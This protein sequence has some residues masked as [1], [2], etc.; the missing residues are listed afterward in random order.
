LGA[1]L[2]LIAAAVLRLSPGD[3][4]HLP[5]WPLSRDGDLVA[6][7]GAPLRAEGAEVERLG[8][9]LWSVR[10]APGAAT[11]R[12][13]AGSASATAPVEPAPGTIA[14][15]ASPPVAVKGRDTE[16]ALAVTVVD[17][18]GRVDPGTAAPLL[19]CSAGSI[20]DL[21]AVGP[22]R[23]A[24]RYQLPAAHYPEL[25]VITALAPRCPLCPTPRAVGAT[26]VPLSAA[27]D[28]PG[29]TEPHVHISVEVGGRVFGPVTAA[30][31][32]AFRIPLVVPPGERYGQ[33]ESVDPLGTRRREP[34]DLRLPPVSQ[35]ACS[36]WPVTLPA[37]GR[38]QAG[39]WC[40]AS[41]ARGTPVP[42]A[43]L[44]IRATLGR[45]GPL[46]PAGGG[47]FLARY[48]APGGGGG[49]RDRL[50]A[51]FPAGGPASVQEVEIA[52][53]TG[54]PAELGYEL[55]REPAPLGIVQVARTWAR[56]AR[57]DA[58]GTPT[59][60]PGAVEG[61]VAPG[62]FV[63]RKE[64]G[65]WLQAAELR[66]ELPPEGEVARLFLW[67]EGSEWVA[68]ARGVAG[69]PVPGIALAFGSGARAV[70]DARG[71]ARIPAG[72]GRTEAVRA[73]GGARAAG[74]GAST[75]S[76]PATA[77]S[78]VQLVPLA[79][80]S[81]VDVRAWAEG[82]V[83]RWKVIGPDGRPLAGRGVRLEPAGVR[84][85]AQE[86]DGDGGRCSVEG[87]GIVAVVDAD[88]GVAAVVE[89]R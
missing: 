16:V 51:V 7:Q 68:A 18:S 2:S 66:L 65:D 52:L 78:R 88:T 38:S 36:A 17:A 23:F 33:G 15:Q 12:L 80:A 37:D 21:R 75:P 4:I 42:R 70:T 58:V 13:R 26:V 8:A 59:G 79:P 73:P 56:D 61:F 85:G 20:A 46:E 55:E 77:L 28:L 54:A 43:R 53:A 41:D 24:A 25:A 89:V 84:L 32:G 50:R 10:P 47:L 30:G 62:R 39:I 69:G 19:S 3:A 44:E 63:A 11:V 82:R 34:I 5:P 1:P 86:R 6:T 87:S 49:K 14:I 83:L 27:I 22:G 45:V 48:T 9:G 29:H 40:L 64:P 57:G 71:E 67:R 60:P 31:D 72:P 74:F 35:L 76:V 81:P